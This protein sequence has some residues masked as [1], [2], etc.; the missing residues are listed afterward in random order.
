MGTGSVWRRRGNLETSCIESVIRKIK[1]DILILEV[2]KML[3]F[4][5]GVFLG[6]NFGVAVMCLMQIAKKSDK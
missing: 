3:T 5:A 1:P 2:V 6:A 4:I